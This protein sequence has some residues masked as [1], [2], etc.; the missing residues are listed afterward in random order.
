MLRVVQ[1]L[2]KIKKNCDA[3]ISN[4]FENM[5]LAEQPD[6]NDPTQPKIFMFDVPTKP[7]RIPLTLYSCYTILPIPHSELKSVTDEDEWI[8]QKSNEIYDTLCD[9]LKDED[10]KSTLQAIKPD[11]ASKIYN[12]LKRG[13][14]FEF[15]DS[16]KIS[17]Q[18]I[19]NLNTQLVLSHASEAMQHLHKTRLQ[20]NKYVS[21]VACDSLA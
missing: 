8:N 20:K 4:A 15:L 1:E 16:A 14:L 5:C 19:E 21:E 7:D 2:L 11:F 17:V 12:P 6:P 13:H 18:K 9:S 3:L 10:F